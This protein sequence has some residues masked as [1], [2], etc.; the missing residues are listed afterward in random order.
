MNTQILNNGDMVIT[1]PK[2]DWERQMAHL[3]SLEPQTQKE[4]DEITVLMQLVKRGTKCP[5][6]AIVNKIVN[7]LKLVKGQP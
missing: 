1:I 2:E 3:D 5:P 4:F 6:V 7:H